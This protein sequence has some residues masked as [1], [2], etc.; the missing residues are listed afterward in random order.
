M[1]KREERIL[2]IIFKTI[3]PFV[4]PLF[5][6]EWSILQMILSESCERIIPN[7]QPMTVATQLYLSGLEDVQ[8]KYIALNLTDQESQNC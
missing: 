7:L 2:D 5:S 1:R 4:S 6:R 3:S 8:G